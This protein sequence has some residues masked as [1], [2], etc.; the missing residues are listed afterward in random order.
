MFKIKEVI[1][2]PEKK[3]RRLVAIDEIVIKLEDKQIYVL[4]IA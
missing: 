2:Q 4:L 3:R 1:N